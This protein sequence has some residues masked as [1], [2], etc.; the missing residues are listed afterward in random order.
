MFESSGKE[1]REGRG[2]RRRLA[3]KLEGDAVCSDLLLVKDSMV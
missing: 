2:E 1:G 3:F